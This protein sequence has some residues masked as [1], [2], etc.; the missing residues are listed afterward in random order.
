[1]GTTEMDVIE[2]EGSAQLVFGG[3]SDDLIDASI[4]SEGGNWIYG[5]S[6]D[7]TLI[8]GEDDHYSGGKGDDKFFAMN[9]GDNIIHGGAGADQFWIATA[10]LPDGINTIKDFTSGEDVLGIA[11]L[12][13]GFED[14]SIT[15][16][17]D[18]ALIAASGTDLAILTDVA[19]DSLSGDNFAF[20]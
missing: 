3:G 10:E 20:G 12:G 8:L 5:G 1:F 9:G 18:N 16:Q 4:G 7:D 19:A 6:G 17:G 13:I 11:G 2:V 15:Q 14:V